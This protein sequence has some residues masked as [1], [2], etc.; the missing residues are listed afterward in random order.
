MRVGIVEMERRGDG[1]G[2]SRRGEGTVRFDGLDGE[3]G[4]WAEGMDV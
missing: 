1:K 4:K 3:G 2:S